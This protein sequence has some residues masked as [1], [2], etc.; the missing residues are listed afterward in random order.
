MRDCGHLHGIA[1]GGGGH[2]DMIASISRFCNA[3][4]SLFIP[5]QQT[6]KGDI[7][8]V[9]VRLSV[10]KGSPLAA[11]I[12][13]RSL[14]NFYSM[15][16]PLKN[17]TICSFIKMWQKLLPR[18]PFFFSTYSTYLLMSV[19]YMKAWMQV[20]AILS[21]YL[22][23]GAL[24]LMCNFLK[25]L[26]KNVAMATFSLCTFLHLP[27]SIIIISAITSKLFCIFISNLVCIV[28]FI[29]KI[30]CFLRRP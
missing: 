2:R 14:P 18:Q 15:F 4:L 21:L 27:S 23:K 7:E 20:D 6:L 11:T 8:T 19:P 25:I 9:S 24:P 1:N 5:R 30:F 13:Y 10:R 29:E 28:G 12:F 3:I 17:F 22:H 16:I 26:T